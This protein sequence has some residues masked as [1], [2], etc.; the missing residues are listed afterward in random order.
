[1]SQR[2]GQRSFR[3]RSKRRDRAPSDGGGT[4]RAVAVDS[5]PRSPVELPAT[6]TVDQLGQG[7][8]GTIGSKVGLKD[9]DVTA[10][11]SDRSRGLLKIGPLARGNGYPC[12]GLGETGR[13]VTAYTAPT[14]S[15]QRGLTREIEKLR[16]THVWSLNG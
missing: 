16:T 1:M 14:A 6:S 15:D 10:G 9:K 8:R 7:L 5:F 2:R 4:P 12:T 3:G 13:N 11:C